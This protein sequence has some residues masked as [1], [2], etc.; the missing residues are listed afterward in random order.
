MAPGPGEGL[1]NDVFLYYTMYCTQEQEQEQR[2]AWGIIVCYCT[3]P[4][5]HPGADPSAVQCV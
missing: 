5:P 4:I 3:H 1:G 2:Q